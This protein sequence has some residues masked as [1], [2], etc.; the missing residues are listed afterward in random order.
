MCEVLFLGG[1]QIK[2][3]PTPAY[4]A[5]GIESPDKSRLPRVRAIAAAA[6][7]TMQKVQTL[8]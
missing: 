1:F 4:K 2:I 3:R 8:E 6:G 7:A 5:C